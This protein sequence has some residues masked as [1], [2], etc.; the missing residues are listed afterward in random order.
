MNALVSQRILGL[1]P[2]DGKQDFHHKE[3]FENDPISL[4]IKTDIFGRSMSFLSGNAKG[5]KL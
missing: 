4:R 1:N 2:P 3:H 5:V